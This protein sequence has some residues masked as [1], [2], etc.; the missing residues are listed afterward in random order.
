MYDHT[1]QKL[2]SINPKF[3]WEKIGLAGKWNTNVHLKTLEELM[4]KNGHTNKKNMI[5][6]IDCEGCEWDSLKDVPENVFLKFKYILMEFH[7]EEN[8][9]L[10]LYYNVLKK[11][12]KNH[13]VIY[14]HCYHRTIIVI[15][16]NIFCKFFEVSYVNKKNNSFVEDDSIYPIFEFDYYNKREQLSE[17]N[18][19][20]LKLYN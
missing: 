8:G 6:K 2:P 1:I 16:N 12:S 3:H 11:L 19:N 18:L 17:M 14:I 9:S 4:A 10:E 13:Q 15:G 5:L 7:L 20:I